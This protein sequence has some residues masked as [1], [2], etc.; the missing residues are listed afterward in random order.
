MHSFHKKPL[1]KFSAIRIFAGAIAAFSLVIVVSPGDGL[2]QDKAAV[3][4]PGS[5]NDQSWNAQ[6]YSGVKKLKSMGW[7]VAYSENVQ[8]SDMAEALQD[9]S[10]K[11]YTLIIGHTGRFLSPMEL[12]GPKY[13]KTTFIVGSGNAGA[14]KNVASIDFN[15][16]QFGYL[17]GVLAARMNKTGKIGSVNGLEGLPNVVAQVGAYQEGSKECT[18]RHSDKGHLHS[19]H[20]GCG[21]RQRSS[22]VFD[23]MGSRLR[24]RKAECS[25]TWD[26]PGSKG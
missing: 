22:I 12:V 11:G 8:P 16:T 19:G 1:G 14:G 18:T 13:P 5:I 6:G 17:I 21:R 3:L 10:R 26:S 2:A 24:E 9:Y 23:R 25:P 7:D 15:N 20:G 4:L